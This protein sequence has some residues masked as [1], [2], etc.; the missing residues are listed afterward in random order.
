LPPQPELITCLPF[1]L[2]SKNTELLKGFLVTFILPFIASESFF[3]SF[4]LEMF[5]SIFSA[6][7]SGFFVV[8]GGVIL[9]F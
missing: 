9:F 7:Y 6:K 3:L 5:P 4:H 2:R 8:V 1:T